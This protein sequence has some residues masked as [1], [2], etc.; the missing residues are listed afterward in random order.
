MY[1]IIDQVTMFFLLA[2]ESELSFLDSEVPW[3]PRNIEWCV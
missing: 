1:V 2:T 3:V